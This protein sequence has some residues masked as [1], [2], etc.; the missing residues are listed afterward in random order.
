MDNQGSRKAEDKV[1]EVT[2]EEREEGYETPEDISSRIPQPTSPPPPPRKNPRWFHAMKV[3]NSPQ[4]EKKPKS[5]SPIDH[6]R[7]LI[8]NF[9]LV[10]PQNSQVYSMCPRLRKT[11]FLVGAC[12]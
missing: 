5:S 1:G 8:L 10:L 4:E 3:K 12:S 2:E 6:H 7:P 11:S 9:T